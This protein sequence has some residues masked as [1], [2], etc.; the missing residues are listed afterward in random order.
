[1]Y[2][3]ELYS[4]FNLWLIKKNVFKDLRTENGHTASFEDRT[5]TFVCRECTTETPIFYTFAGMFS[6]LCTPL[7]VMTS[8]VCQLST[9]Y[10]P[11][12][13]NYLSSEQKKFYF[14]KSSVSH[15]YFPPFHFRE[16]CG[17]KRS[18]LTF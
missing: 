9:S 13:M 15:H 10:N 11:K 6:F 4:K 1:M 5:F 18:R 12:M 14:C 7:M 3:R 2:F 8:T 17:P 16:H